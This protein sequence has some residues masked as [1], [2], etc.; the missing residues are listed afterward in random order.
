MKRSP[1][2]KGGCVLWGL[3][4]AAGGAYGG[5]VG[6]VEGHQRLSRLETIPGSFSEVMIT[7]ERLEGNS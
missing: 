7:N 3:G 5:A 4:S 6:V 2:S 1:C